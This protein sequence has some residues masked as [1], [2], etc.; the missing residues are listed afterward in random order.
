MFY[1]LSKQSLP[2]KSVTFHLNHS[3]HVDTKS[4]I[5]LT[6]SVLQLSRFSFSSTV[7]QIFTRIEKSSINE[8]C[9]LPILTLPSFVTLDIKITVYLSRSF[10][11]FGSNIHQG[12]FYDLPYSLILLSILTEFWHQVLQSILI[13]FFVYFL[14]PYRITIAIE[15]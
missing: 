7:L 9:H 13:V 1:Q 10:K 12:A 3:C 15:F 5:N 11:K 8:Y 2:I 6:A 14:K 4:R